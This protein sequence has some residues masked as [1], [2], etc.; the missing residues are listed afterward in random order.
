MAV[1]A[2]DTA[3]V[4]ATLIDGTG[5]APLPDSA[6]VV[7]GER[8]TWAGPASELDRS[9]GPKVVDVAGRYVMPGLMDANVHLIFQS[10]PDVLLRYEDGRYDDLALEAAQVTLRAGITTV[11]DT[12]GPV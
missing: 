6:V 11:F 4:G 1:Q 3:Y 8:V 2:S 7:S 5:R 10:D 9:A 12:M